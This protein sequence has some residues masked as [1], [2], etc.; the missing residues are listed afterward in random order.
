MQWVFGRQNRLHVRAGLT[1]ENWP[2]LPGCETMGKEVSGQEGVSCEITG[3][4]GKEGHTKKVPNWAWASGFR[5]LRKQKNRCGEGLGFPWATESVRFPDLQKELVPSQR[6]PCLSPLHGTN[7]LIVRKIWC[8]RIFGDNCFLH[9]VN[10]SIFYYPAA[11]SLINSFC[12][13]PQN[14][15][16]PRFKQ[17][18]KGCPFCSR[19]RGQVL[20]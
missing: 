12:S 13:S 16:L 19:S 7:L 9:A 17:S 5:V 10:C 18:H 8:N 3:E 4:E 15:K 2:K 11:S 20:S 6:N 1:R 14:Q